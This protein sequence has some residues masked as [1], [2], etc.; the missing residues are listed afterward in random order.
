MSYT[1]YINGVCYTYDDQGNPISKVGMGGTQYPAP[2]QPP[3]PDWKVGD[4]FVSNTGT[5]GKVTGADGERISFQLDD[6]YLGEVSLTYF[7]RNVTHAPVGE[8]APPAVRD[9]VCGNKWCGRTCD[10]GKPCW[11]CETPDGV[12]CGGGQ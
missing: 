9:R 3:S 7:C 8:T 12:I 5:T 1:R 4:R 6:G 10:V 2:P 11:N